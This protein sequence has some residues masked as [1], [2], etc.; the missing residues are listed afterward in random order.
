MRIYCFIFF[1]LRRF[2]LCGIFG[3]GELDVGSWGFVWVGLRVEE[4]LDWVICLLRV[5]VFFV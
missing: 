1:F 5:Y 3:S 4:G 2:G